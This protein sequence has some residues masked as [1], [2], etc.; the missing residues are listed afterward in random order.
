MLSFEDEPQSN[1]KTIRWCSV[2]VGRPANG[3]GEPAGHRLRRPQL[4]RRRPGAGD[5]A[6]R[7]AARR[8]RDLRAQDLRP[9]VRR[10]D[11]LGQRARP[12]RRPRRHH[13][14]ARRRRRAGRRRRST[15]CRCATRS[16]SS[17]S[18]PTAP[19]RCRCAVSAARPRSPTASP[20]P[21]RP[22][23]RCR[24]PTRSAYPV[25]VEDPVGCP[26]FTGRSVTGFDPAAPTPAWMA[27]RIQ[28]AGMRPISLAVDVTNYVMLELGQPIHGFDRDKLAGPIVVRRARAGERLTTLDGADRELSTEDLLI[29]DDSGPIGLGGRDGRRDDRAVGDDDQHLHRGRALGPGHDLPHRAPP[30]AAVRG[31]QALRARHRPD[32]PARRRRPGGRAADDVRR[33]HG[34]A[35]RDVRRRRAV[36]RRRSRSTPACPRGSPAWTSRRRRRS[37]TCAP[38]AA[39]S[40]SRARHR[41][42]RSPRRRGAAT[43]PTPSTWSRRS[44]GSSATPTCRRCCRPPPTAAG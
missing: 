4:R 40:R 42:L 23:G 1:G 43:S 14:A 34:R 39:S 32:H 19:T 9:R 10:D 2:D 37:P 13:R 12:R 8:L 25:V 16:S 36:A 44:P 24:R 5:P 29:T 18:T 11:L 6:G 35:G 22:T 20:S 41:L 28:L 7:R 26:V 27:R 30:Q 21:T 17:R 38:S 31:V 33:R 3:T 15:C